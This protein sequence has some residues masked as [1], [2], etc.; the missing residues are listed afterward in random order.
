M[1]MT[2]TPVLHTQI[3]M[4]VT[5]TPVPHAQIMMRVTNTPV[6]RSDHDSDKDTSVARSDRDSHAQTMTM[7]KTPVLHASTVTVTKTPVL[8]AQ[9]LTVRDKDTCVARSDLL[10]RVPGPVTGGRVNHRA[11]PF[12]FKSCAGI[13]G[14]HWKAEPLLHTLT[15][16]RS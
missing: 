6:A 12:S 13:R 16:S 7:T 3:T 11:A 14:L 10:A 9:T 8:H 2:K 4:T 1:K 15:T 5:K